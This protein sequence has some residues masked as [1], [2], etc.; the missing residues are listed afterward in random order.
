MQDSAGVVRIIRISPIEKEISVF[1]HG[2]I[3][4]LDACNE[5]LLAYKH[6]HS[7]GAVQPHIASH[8]NDDFKVI[9]FIGLQHAPRKSENTWA[10]ACG[11][12]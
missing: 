8:A 9:T 6:F 10:S 4:T 11:R 12:Q 3:T 7:I 2:A 1:A 5:F